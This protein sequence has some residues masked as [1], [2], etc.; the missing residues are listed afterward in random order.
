MIDWLEMLTIH[1]ELKQFS[2]VMLEKKQKEF[3]TSSERELLAWIYLTKN[4]CTPLQLSK[5]SGMKKEAVS[6][7]L[8][9]L[10]EKGCISREKNALDDRSYCLVLTEAGDKALQNDY[11]MMLQKYYDLYREMGDEFFDLFQLISKANQI[12]AQRSDNHEV[13]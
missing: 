12:L 2:R 4:D 11:G 5:A 13:L 7:C 1:Q 8:K 9:C 10:H 3:L 6:R